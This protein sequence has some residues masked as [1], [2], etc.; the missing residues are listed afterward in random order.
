MWRVRCV[1]RVC[2]DVRV[3]AYVRVCV[4]VSCV[5]ALFALCAHCIHVYASRK[6]IHVRGRISSSLPPLIHTTAHPNQASHS[7][8]RP[9]PSLALQS[10]LAAAGVLHFTRHMLHE[11]FTCHT[12]NVTLHASQSTHPS[13]HITHHTS[14]VTRHT[15]QCHHEP[16]SQTSCVAASAPAPSP[17]LRAKCVPGNSQRS[18]LGCRRSGSRG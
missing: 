15:S 1:W 5:C 9:W 12:S 18:W 3:R 6:C 17:K 10:L 8:H 13:S 11:H 2:Y 4:R 7:T 16:L 14:H